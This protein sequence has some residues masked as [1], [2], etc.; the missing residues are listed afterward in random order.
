MGI[1]LPYMHIYHAVYLKHIILAVPYISVRKEKKETERGEMH[2]QGKFV[3]LE[4]KLH[5]LKKNT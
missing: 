4:T 5:D 3:F 2:I 1:I